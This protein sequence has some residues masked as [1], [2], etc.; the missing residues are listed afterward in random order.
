M[1]SFLVINDF[2]IINPASMGFLLDWSYKKDH[3]AHTQLFSFK[4][5][6]CSSLFSSG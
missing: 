4:K 5:Y 6:L 3:V 1:S 2:Y